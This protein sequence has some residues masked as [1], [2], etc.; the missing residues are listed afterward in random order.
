MYKR[1]D[2]NNLKAQLGQCVDLATSAMGGSIVAV[3]DEFF[4]P[5]IRMIDAAPAVSAPGK[6]DDHGQWMDGWETKRHNQRDYD[7][8]IIKLGFAGSVSGFDI[9]TSF[10]TGNQ[11]PAASVDAVFCP[12]GEDLDNAQWTEILP[13]V[14]LPPSCHNAF[15]LNNATK[16]FTHVR[17]NN[18]PDGG[19][20][21][22]RVYGQV[23]P[24]WPANVSEV[25][26]LAYVGYGGRVVSATDEHYAPASN[27]LLPGRGKDADDGWQTKRSRVPN[28]NDS[29]VIRLGAKGHILKVEVDTSDFKGNYPNRIKLE[30]TN[31]NA[32]VPDASSQWVTVVQPSSTGPHGQFYFDASHTDQVFSHA[33]VSIIPDGGFKRIRL[34]GVRQG[35]QIPSLPLPNFPKRI[36]VAEP[37]TSEKYAPFGEVIEAKLNIKVTGA[38]QGTAKKFH[39]V[40]KVTNAFPNDSGKVNLCVFRSSPT[41][42]L[43][44]KVKLFERHPY[45]SQQF[46][47]MTNGKT[48]GYLVIV[49]LNNEDGSPDLTTTKAF[50]AS[51][52]QGISYRRGVWHHPMISLEHETD[53]ACLVHENGT[54]NDDC[55]EAYVDGVVVQV[56]GFQGNSKI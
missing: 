12:E 55:Q 47:P 18:Y 14:D 44:F 26:D 2:H 53:F 38:N 23:A 6:F 56:P 32:E 45:S 30:A 15:V 48:R 43:P 11:A 34:H 51:S 52:T 36:I 49:C 50:I 35:G 42:E 9:D 19:I 27:I 40:A 4:A 41:K 54:P 17:I 13:R 33:R 29:V 5:A 25:L 7:W 3:T 24:Q 28:H 20:A 39:H 21:R 31:T 22:F 46:V 10:F 1:I 16:V 8:C 37:L